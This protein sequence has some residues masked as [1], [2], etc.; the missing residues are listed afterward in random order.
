MTLGISGLIAAYIVLAV[1]LLSINLYSKWSWHV[2][3]ITIIITSAFYIVSYFSFP[4][5]LGWPTKQ[6]L[7]SHFRLL[8]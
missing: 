8:S 2:K 6:A 5:L 3:A 7:P 4:P 1:L